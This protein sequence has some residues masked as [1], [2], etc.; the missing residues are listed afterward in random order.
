NGLIGK[1]NANKGKT[2]QHHCENNDFYESGI[3]FI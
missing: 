2:Q 3:H 1:C